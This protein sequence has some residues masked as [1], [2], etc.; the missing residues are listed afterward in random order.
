MSIENTIQRMNRVRRTVA[1]SLREFNEAVDA[2]KDDAKRDTLAVHRLIALE[3]LR[4]IVLK[5]PVDT[6]AARGS[7]RLN[8]G[9]APEP[10]DPNTQK[11]PW[12]III[13]ANSLLRTLKRG[14]TVWISSSLDYI[15]FLED[16]S[17]EQAPQGM[18]AVT[19]EELKTVFQ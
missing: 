13:E 3:A 8:I 15:L 17:S 11:S 2:S 12:T 4:R 18:I 1:N 5:T 10:D 7:W 14:K 6:G 9:E 16:G 19:L